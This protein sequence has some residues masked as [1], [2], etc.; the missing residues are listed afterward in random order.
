VTGVLGPI[1]PADP[2]FGDI[3]NIA[4]SGAAR[5]FPHVEPPLVPLGEGGVLWATE[6]TVFHPVTKI[7]VYSTRNLGAS[8][9]SL[10]PQI[11]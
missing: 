2:L 5:F 4:K 11:E 1:C 10:L 8:N 6:V 3:S 9:R 7:V